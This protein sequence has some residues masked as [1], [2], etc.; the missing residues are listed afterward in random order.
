MEGPTY[1]GREGKGGEGKGRGRVSRLLRF[2][3]GSRGAR[4]VT[5]PSTAKYPTY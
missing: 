3:P 2:P 4:I 5:D 1:K